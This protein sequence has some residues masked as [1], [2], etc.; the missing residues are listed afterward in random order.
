MIQKLNYAIQVGELGTLAMAIGERHDEFA[1]NFAGDK[2]MDA[3]MSGEKKETDAIITAIKRTKNASRADELDAARDNA[4]TALGDTAKAYLLLGAAAEKETAREIL[5]VLEKYRGIA[6]LNNANESAQLASLFKDADAPLLKTKIE[7]LPNLEAAFAALR[8]AES[9]FL[10]ETKAQNDQK[11]GA[12]ENASSVKKRL[13]SLLNDQ[14]IPY[15][16]VASVAVPADYGAFAD[17][18]AVLV[19]KANAVVVQRSKK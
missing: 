19:Q 3:V 9:A 1:A 14:L 7:A 16:N 11:I 18:V 13:V 15:L 5:T 10:A 4:F 17:A 6:H 12:G 8:A 2:V